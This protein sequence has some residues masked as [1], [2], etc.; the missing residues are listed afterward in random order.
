MPF[1]GSVTL[2]HTLPLIFLSFFRGYKIGGKSALI[3]S[4]MKVIFSFHTPPSPNIISYI[5]VIVLDYFIP[6]FI[7]GTTSCYS[8][9]FKNEK[10]NIIL[11][12]IV[13]EFFRF[14]LSVISGF[15]IWSGYFNFSSEIL[16]YCVIYNLSYMIPN[17][18]ISLVV[19]AMVY[20]P[21][22][23]T[24]TDFNHTFR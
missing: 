23:N 10:Y 14:I 13:S 5:L 18:I 16:S 2:A 9:I 4:F 15:I 24:I 7:V 3:F 21:I 1:G 22:K 20:K 17:L 19:F 8:R 6:Y 12:I 11:G